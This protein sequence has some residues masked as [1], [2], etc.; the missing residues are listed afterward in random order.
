MPAATEDEAWRAMAEAVLAAYALAPVALARIPQGLVNL[1]LEVS[2]AD[3]QRYVLQR[4]HPVFDRS[5]NDNLDAV[6]THLAARGLPTPRLVRTRDGTADVR[7]DDGVWR[8]LTFVAGRAFDRLQSG[9]Q[10]RAAGTLLARFHAALTDFPGELVSTRPPIH[11]FAR[12]LARLDQALADRGSHRLADAVRAAAADLAH[13][14]G[15]PPVL[16]RP[17][18]VHGDPKISNMLFDASGEVAVCMIDLD[19]VARM[20][21]ALELGDAFRSWCNPR[22]EDDL[23]GRFDLALFEA[24]LTGYAAAARRFMT[25]TEAAAIVPATLQIQLELAAR[26]L[27]DALEESYFGWDPTRY[28][29]RGEHNLARARGQLAAARSLCAQLAAAGERVARAFAGVR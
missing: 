16:D 20:P 1:T 9:A 4:L 23:D 3:G 17:R 29:A 27:A 6:T 24:G 7:A 26:F 12:H 22:T 25:A 10:A 18:L 8:L 13:L 11:D 5:V 28:P 21:L 15:A 2:T 14:R 19:T